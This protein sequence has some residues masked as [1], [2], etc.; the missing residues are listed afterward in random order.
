[1]RRKARRILQDYLEYG[2]RICY[3]H[4]LGIYR[5]LNY[6][7]NSWPINQML[8]EMDELLNQ[9]DEEKRDVLAMTI[10]TF[11]KCRFHY[12]KTADKLYTHVNTIRYRIKLIEDLWDVDLS[13]DRGETSVQCAG[14]AASAVDEEWVL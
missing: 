12:Q 11:V 14:E 6:P 7:E 8:G 1:M 5:L 3:Y 13:S 9:M 2:E 4:D 10:R